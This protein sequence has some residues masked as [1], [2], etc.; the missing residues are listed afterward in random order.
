MLQTVRWTDNAC[1]LLDQTKLPTETV[2]VDIVD[3]RQMWDAIK[4]LVVRG[5]PAI[6]VAAAFGVYLG[7]RSFSGELLPFYDRL[8]EVCDYLATSRPT[9]VNLFWAIDRQRRVA[10]DAGRSVRADTSDE[11]TIALVKAKLL[12]TAR[13][14]LDEDTAICRRI[15]EHGIEL[16]MPLTAADGVIRLLT[17]CNA[18][19]LATVQYGTALAPVYVGVERGL[20]FH[21]YADETRPLLQ[22]SRITAYELQANGVPAT[23]ICDNMAATVMRQDKVKAVIVGT[24]RVAANGDVANKIGT[25]GVAILAKHFGIPFFVAAPT[26]SIDMSLATGD[27]I[28]IEARSPDEVTHG[29]GRQTAPD[30]IDVYNPAFDVTPA[31]LVTAIITERGVV[32]NPTTESLRLTAL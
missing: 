10:R 25:F 28:P 29:M 30:G 20:K 32:K 27:L 5:A 11:H 14:M 23:V 17:H 26:S 2:Y 1:R 19:G 22:G 21:V 13:Q 4:R 31:E 8:N 24:D 3:E 12:A 15:G 16:L 7:V 9:A 18:G 6:G